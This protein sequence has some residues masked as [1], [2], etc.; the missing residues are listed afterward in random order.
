MRYYPLKAT[1]TIS[2]TVTHDE[3]RKL[4]A[5]AHCKNQSLVD[6]CRSRLDCLTTAQRLT[7]QKAVKRIIA[8]RRK[9]HFKPL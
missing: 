9:R 4:V 7:R 8:A 2:I 5:E 3:H 6:Y 1:K